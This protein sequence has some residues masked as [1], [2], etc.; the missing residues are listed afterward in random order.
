MSLTMIQ[1]EL[2]NQFSIKSYY[3]RASEMKI[4]WNDLAAVME[5]KDNYIMGELYQPVKR[6]GSSGRRTPEQV[7]DDGE[8]TLRL[9]GQ[10]LYAGDLRSLDFPRLFFHGKKILMCM[11]LQTS[12]FIR[13]LTC[14]SMRIFRYRC[15]EW[16]ADDYEICCISERIL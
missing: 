3:Y 2:I 15:R 11:T 13:N 4:D 12:V 10:V 9:T 1:E 7:L 16:K 5:I 6:P 14:S 8:I